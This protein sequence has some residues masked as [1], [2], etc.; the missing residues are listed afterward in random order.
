MVSLRRLVHAAEVGRWRL[1]RALRLP[2]LE[3]LPWSAVAFGAVAL[4]AAVGAALGVVDL[5]AARESDAPAQAFINIWVQLGI[6]L[7]AALVSYALTPKPKAPEAIAAQAPVVEDGKGVVR[8]YGTVWIDDSIMLGWK[9]MGTEPI[10]KKG[11]KK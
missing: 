6:M 5:F 7:V 10:R 11:G 9:Q 4:A 1:S 8:I 3:M 2:P